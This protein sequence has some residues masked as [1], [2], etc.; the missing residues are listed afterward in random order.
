MAKGGSNKEAERAREAEEARQARIRQGTENINQV[1]DENFTPQFYNDQAKAYRQYAMP[2]VNEQYEDAGNKLAF[3]LSRRGLTD[4][5]IRADKS[6]DLSELY[7]L[8]RQGVVDKAREYSTNA[9]T[10]AE[11][12]R[13][14]LILTLQSTG[15][16]AGAAQ[17]ANARA[18]ALSRPPAYSPLEDVF[19]SFTSGLATQAA[20]ERAQAAGSGVKPRFNLG[21]YGPSPDSV[22]VT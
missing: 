4:S 14:D 22:R 20:L 5:S 16:A 13:N 21:L 11:D 9:R 1:F 19:L 18:D 17:A 2:Q 3:D 7:E 8:N 6:A 15:D 10:G 12:A